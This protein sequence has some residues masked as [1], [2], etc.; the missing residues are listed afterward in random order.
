MV[1]LLQNNLC[2]V[3]LVLIN[4][5][6]YFSSLS[7]IMSFWVWNQHKQQ[8][9]QEIPSP[10]CYH[11]LVNYKSSIF[12]FGGFEYNK[13]A[14]II[15]N[16]GLWEYKNNN[17]TKISCIN[18]PPERYFHS[19]IQY[20]GCIFIFGGMS[21]IQYNYTITLNYKN[22]LYKFNINTQEWIREKDFGDIPSQR[23]GHSAVVYNGSMIVFGGKQQ[24]DEKCFLNDLYEYQIQLRKWYKIIANGEQPSPRCAHSA[25]VYKDSMYVFG[26]WGDQNMYF[27]EFFKF[28]YHGKMWT[29][30]ITQSLNDYPQKRS[31]HS[32]IVYGDNL[33]VIFGYDGKYRYN[34][35]LQYNFVTK[36]WKVLEAPLKSRAYHACTILNGVLYVHGG[37][38]NHG[39]LTDELHF[40]KLK[41]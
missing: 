41:K 15:G 2:I 12:L 17:W 11:T 13:Q 5:Q 25:A 19:A 1:G 40:V 26:G 30:I 10:R 36:I 28:D 35:I 8:V 31:G 20:Q 16:N 34:L 9:N 32:C 18:P 3:K 24:G 14:T 38:L 27:N 39:V 29:K 21:T 33:Y 22:D 4:F 6:S 37:T 7:H 23:A